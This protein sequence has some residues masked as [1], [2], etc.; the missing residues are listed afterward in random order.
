MS[1]TLA[2]FATADITPPLNLEMAGFGPFM[3]RKATSIHDPLMAHAMVLAA[4]GKRVAVVG[5]DVCGVTWEVTRKVRDLVEAGTGIPGQHVLVSATHTHSGPAVPC[6]IGWGA[7]DQGYLSGLPRKIAQAVIA[8]SQNLQP[9][10]LSY[11]EVPIGGIAEDREWPGGPVDKKLRVL[12]FKHDD[13]VTGFVVHYSVHNVLFSE[14]MH[15]YTA[16]LTGVGM[17]K[18]VKDYP[19]AVGIYLQG[20]CGDINPVPTGGINFA[21]PEVC[22]QRLEQLS[23]RFAGLTEVPK[24]GSLLR[25]W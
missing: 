4:G 2:G 21:S 16:D 13:Q 6:W 20:S 8:A 22:E 1:M 10:E 24:E 3:E 7:Q 15:A 14:L 12:R 18:V 5:C 9:V 11:G 17:A 25:Q 23:D 19:G